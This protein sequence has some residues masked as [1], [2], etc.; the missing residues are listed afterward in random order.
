MLQQIMSAG[1]MIATLRAKV[2]VF[3]GAQQIQ[4]ASATAAAAAAPAA[5][6]GGHAHLEIL[7]ACATSNI[8]GRISSF[9]TAWAALWIM[10]YG[11]PATA[12]YAKRTLE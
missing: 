8:V 6:A 5:R 7:S 1:S 9:V 3:A 2:I 10:M 11:R 4:N 12:T